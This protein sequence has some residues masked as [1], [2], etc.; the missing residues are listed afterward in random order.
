MLTGIVVTGAHR[1]ADYPVPLE[2]MPAETY[3]DGGRRIKAIVHTTVQAM[4]IAG[5]DSIVIGV[6]EWTVDVVKLCK[7]GRE[8]FSVPLV[9][10]WSEHGDAQDVL[11][12]FYPWIRGGRVYI[13]PGWLAIRPAGLFYM[14]ESRMADNNLECCVAQIESDGWAILM[15]SSAIEAVRQLYVSSGYMTLL[16]A[17][18]L[19]GVKYSRINVR[20]GKASY[21]MMDKDPI[22][23]SRSIES[24]STP[25]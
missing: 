6:N 10:A 14:M 4:V 13:M 19:S 7:S 22:I 5:C 9:Y 15:N 8:Q 17:I 24:R 16:E 12:E 18:S 23:H 25:D 3:Y 1:I 20:S 21:G 11:Q 2:I